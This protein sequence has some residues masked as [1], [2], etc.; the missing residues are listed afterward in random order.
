MSFLNVLFFASTAISAAQAAKSSRLQ[1]EIQE[2]QL[3]AEEVRVRRSHRQA[4][5]AAQ[6]QR[7]RTVNSG[8]ASGAQGSSGLAGGLSSLRSQLGTELGVSSQLSNIASDQTNLSIASGKAAA[9]SRLFGNVSSIAFNQSPTDPFGWLRKL[10]AKYKGNP[11][12]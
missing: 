6:I 3:E 1:R 11:N 4:I 2:K 9:S 5:R 10:D 7:A 12:G 8:I